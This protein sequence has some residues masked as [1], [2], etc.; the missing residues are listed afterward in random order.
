MQ[1]KKKE[2]KEENNCSTSV[3]IEKNG[4][5][6]ILT[7]EKQKKQKKDGLKVQTTQLEVEELIKKILE[8]AAREF[9]GKQEKHQTRDEE[10]LIIEQ[11]MHAPKSMWRVPLTWAHSFGPPPDPSLY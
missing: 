1:K 10:E 4:V 11:S 8:I 5:T 7:T 2:K 3:N 9:E 6:K